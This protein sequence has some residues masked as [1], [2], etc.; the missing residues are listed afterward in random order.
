MLG[1][2]HDISSVLPCPFFCFQLP[3]VCAQETEVATK[4]AYNAFLLLHLELV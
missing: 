1:L 2:P 4:Q 3:F